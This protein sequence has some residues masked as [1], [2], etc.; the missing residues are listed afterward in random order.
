MNFDWERS[1]TVG[2]RAEKKHPFQ[3][4]SVE[5]AVAEVR[6]KIVLGIRLRESEVL[7]ICVRL[8][9]ASIM[10]RDGESWKLNDPNSCSDRSVRADE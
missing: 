2:T 5:S 8:E 4:N 9:F 7:E 6:E 1:S 3:D 10:I